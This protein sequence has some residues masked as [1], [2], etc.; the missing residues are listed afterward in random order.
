[1]V[2]NNH[3]AR[4]RGGK[5]SFTHIIGYALVKAL[6]A[7]PAMNHAF[8]EQDG[9]PVVIAPAHV[10]LGLAIDLAKPDG[11]RQLLVPSIKSAEL[12]DF[13][14]FWSAYEDMVKKARGG[15]LTV[16]D[17]AGTTISLTNPGTIGTVHSVPRLMQ[18]QGTIVGVGAME[19]PAEWQGASNETLN[20]NA[21]SKILTLTSTYDHRIIQGAQSGDFLRIVH[22]LLL[23][24]DG[25]TTRSS[26]ACA[27]PTSRS[28]GCRT[29]RPPTT[30]TSTRSPGF[31]SSST[32]SGCGATSW[33]TPTRWNTASAATPTSTS[34][35]HGLTL[36]D[37]DRH[38]AT[39]GFG[40]KPFLK[41]RQILGILRDSY[42]RTIGIEYMHIQDPEQRKWIQDQSRSSAK[43]HPR[44]ADAHPASAQRRRGLRDLP[45]D[46]VRRPEALLPRGRRVR[47]PAAGP[48]PLGG[49]RGGHGRGRASACRT[50]AGST[51]WPTSSA[52][53]TRRSSASSRAATP[54]RSRAPAT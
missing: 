9:K 20:R 49:G 40:G 46:Q 14:H 47:D 43:P 22:H 29:S 3:L 6:K 51:C 37:L 11:T 15:K 17:F 32:P 41:L 24:G 38:F 7:L 8:G 34:P 28:A 54:S 21:V 36:W 12:M 10:N 45:A 1:V 19:Y 30:T 26:R 35:S 31:R 48:D 23:G 13:V 53:P 42:C 44:R 16:D 2:I 50:A 39:G 5:V 18:G 4:S 52:S 33:P 25:S 27:S